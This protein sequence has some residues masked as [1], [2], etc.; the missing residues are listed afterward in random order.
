MRPTGRM[1]FLSQS[2]LF[3]K[4]LAE[5]AR[6]GLGQDAGDDFGAMIQSW[7]A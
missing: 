7:I 2:S 5:D 6:T 3:L 1:L 4:K